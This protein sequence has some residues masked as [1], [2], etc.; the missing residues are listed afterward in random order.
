MCVCVCVPGDVCY[1][2]TLNL[3]APRD[4]AAKRAGWSGTRTFQLEPDDDGWATVK[5]R[6]SLH[7]HCPYTHPVTYL[8][9]GSDHVG[10]VAQAH[11]CMRACVC[12]CIG[13]DVCCLHTPA[14]AC[15][16]VCVCLCMCVCVRA[17]VFVCVFTG[18]TERRVH[19]CP[20]RAILIHTAPTPPARTPL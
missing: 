14:A 6:T 8:G 3:G 20:V 15:P 5:V 1:S 9:Y 19:T 4:A 2:L 13:T 10:A 11:A 7:T 18:R 16:C 17:C 12:V